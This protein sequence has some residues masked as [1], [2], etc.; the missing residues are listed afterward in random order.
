MKEDL[1]KSL[2]QYQNME[3]QLQAAMLQKHQLQLQV[4]EINLALEELGKTKENEVF[5][6]I[7]SIMVKCKKEDATKDLDERKKLSEL[8]INSLTKQEDQLK[9]QLEDMRADLEA[10][11][12]QQQG[13]GE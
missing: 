2:M 5:K 10:S 1:E 6:S 3:K 4:N 11:L 13:A 7:G 8:R 9:N 12:K